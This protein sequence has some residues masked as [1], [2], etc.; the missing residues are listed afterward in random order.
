MA[1]SPARKGRRLR[2]A[3][4]LLILMLLL[5]PVSAAVER[6]PWSDPRWP[7]R[8]L[9]RVPSSARKAASARIHLRPDADG[10]GRDLRMTGPDG[11]DVPFGIVHR[12][13]EGR[14][15]LGFNLRKGGGLYAVYYGNKGSKAAP[16]E[17]PP[18]GLV[19]RTRP[20]PDDPKAG[21]WPE[22]QE[23]L[24]RAG[25]AFGAD[26]WR[27][28]FD[29]YNPFGPQSGYIADYSGY[30]HCPKSGTYRFA[31]ASD[32]S[33]FLLVDDRL[34]VQWPGRH[35]ARRGRRGE[36]SGSVELDKGT[37]RFRYVHFAEGRRAR[38]AAAWIPPGERWWRIIPA[39]AFGEPVAAEVY[40]SERRD[41][42]LC[43]D[44]TARPE[45]YC[46]AGDAKM[47]EFR[48]RSVSTAPDGLIRAYRWSFGDGQVS[49]EPHPR[50]VF[51]ATGLCEVRLTV[52]DTRGA[53]AVCRKRLR[54]EPDRGDQE[55]S[56]EKMARFFER[57]RRYRLDSLPAPSLLGMWRLCRRLGKSEPAA[58]AARALYRRSEEVD[59]LE[60]HEVARWLGGYV[61][62][63][64]LEPA[65][66]EAYLREALASLPKV[67][68]KRRMQT[69][70][71]LADLYLREMDDPERARKECIGLRADFP[72]GDA[73]LRRRALLCI[74]DAWRQE[75]KAEEA[76]G[77]YAEAE[78]TPGFAPDAAPA[79]YKAAAL[80][81]A[82]L[83]LRRGEAEQALEKLEDLLW[84]LPT[85]RLEGRPNVLRVRAEMQRARFDRAARLAETCLRFIEDPN[86]APA[87]R[88]LAGEAR[89]EVGR[90]EEAEEHY[91][92]LLERYPEAPETAEARDA[93]RR[94][95]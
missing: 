6:P 50:H 87:L 66:A 59:P 49:T 34:V 91:R 73:E 55:F 95:R 37:H 26:Y 22:A 47:A 64:G 54:V 67:R 23:T 21:G 42:A 36:H 25:P 4:V 31:T 44:F 78:G 8:K 1:Q 81:Q 41:R 79:L 45:D 19:Y 14:Y 18:V 7:R 86:T 82:E 69:R 71:E 56:R 75:G 11:R 33:S 28:V 68:R 60:R 38:A 12:T 77:A 57:A 65:R 46:E 63:R 35:N 94:L 15:L 92:T 16:R 58:E 88:L 72:R 83:L 24:K 29:A 76:R 61:R 90:T 13:G 43:A 10:G 27:R 9:L 48:F 5:T 89:A 53:T 32:Y 62:R 70:L 20:L 2:T 84:K 39:E 52:T 74:G 17:L 40:E 80:Q 51:L 85:L 3:P 93:L 30:L